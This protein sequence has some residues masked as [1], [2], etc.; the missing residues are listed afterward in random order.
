MR[1]DISIS[2]LTGKELDTILSVVGLIVHLNQF[3]FALSLK[4][5]NGLAKNNRIQ[6]KEL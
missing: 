6:S 2:T 5:G 1:L 4:H 3:A